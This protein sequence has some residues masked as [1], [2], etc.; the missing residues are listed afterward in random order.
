M[1]QPIKIA[2]VISRFNEQITKKLLDD[3]LFAEMDFAVKAE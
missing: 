3:A 2:I 1:T